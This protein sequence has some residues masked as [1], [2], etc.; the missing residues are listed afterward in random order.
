ME[1]MKE[2]LDLLMELMETGEE[3]EIKESSNRYFFNGKV[4]AFFIKDKGSNHR[5]LV[6]F[7]LTGTIIR[8]PWYPKLDEWVYMA[9]LENKCELFRKFFWSEIRFDKIMWSR[10][11]IFKT[12]EEAVEMSETL[13]DKA[14]E[15]LTN[16]EV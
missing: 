3:F 15:R 9:S 8:K 1:T 13:I 7:D 16:D 4:F 12:E 11:L 6:P 14:K 2:R 10:G 5:S